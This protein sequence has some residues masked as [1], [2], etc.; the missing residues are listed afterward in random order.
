[1][2]VAE[3]NTE[4]NLLAAALEYAALGWPVLPLHSWTGTRCTCGRDDC[5][6]PAKHPRTKSGLHD[7]TTDTNKISDWWRQWPTANVGLRTGVAF[8]VLDVDGAEGETNLV[9][10]LVTADA[11]LPGGPASFTGGDGRHLLFQPTGAG[12]RAGILPKVDWR[13]TNGYIVA[14]PSLH[15][16]GNRYRWDDPPS[17][18]L[19]FTPDILKVLVSP[20]DADRGNTGEARAL[21]GGTGDGTAY[22]LRALDAEIDELRRA[23]TGTRNHT[24]NQVA[25]N[26]YQ[27]VSGGELA[28]HAVE[29][30]LQATA[31]AIGLGEHETT[32]TIG[33][34]R[35]GG[36]ASPRNAPVLHVL[37][38][39]TGVDGQPVTTARKATVDAQLPDEFW[40]ARPEL[41][42]I[43]Q[44]AR[45]RLVSPDAV[46]GA[47]LARVA[48]ITPHMVEIPATIGS[49]V[50][51]SYFVALAGP[52][53]AGKSS[54]ADIAGELL[55]APD[56]V[57][58]RLPIGSGEGMVEILFDLVVEEDEKGKPVKVKRQT[59]HAAI[60]HIDE[61][62]VLADL[63]NRQGTTLL[64]TLRTAW[65]HGTLGNTNASAERK[66]IVHGRSY[67]YGITLGIQ[68]E[69]AGPLLADAA[70]GTP[71]RFVWVTALDLQ[72]PDESPPWPGEIDWEPPPGDI[73]R[74]RTVIRDRQ[75][76]HPLGIHPDIVRQV[77]DERRAIVR[78]QLEV[79]AG[80]EHQMLVRLKTAALL[81]LLDHR[82][83]VSTDD[84]DLAGVITGV[85]RRIRHTI[86]GTLTVLSQLREQARADRQAHLEIH[87]EDK[88]GQ[89]AL[90][91]AAK[92]IANVVRRHHETSM[93]AMP[94][95]CAKRCLLSAMAGK[96]KELVGA[97]VAIGEAERL[98]WITADGDRWTPGQARPA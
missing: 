51:L 59:R 45:S 17:T 76:R 70:A 90:T 62:A 80:D 64:P 21:P 50:G 26:L 58:D 42:H 44:A 83:D 46:L 49:P 43:R 53:S 91:S 92:S 35:R 25:Y 30:R 23:A 37:T 9:D 4:T 39:T 11:T 95:G 12:N 82:I 20:P 94:V 27:L 10:H 1:M 40:S 48:A 16:T 74:A 52:S 93:H 77:V 61:G 31:L 56:H 55:P 89:R 73:L 3:P 67:V 81:A 24:L 98:E 18:P 60:F 28:E 8:D 71:Q 68:P 15:A 69:K 19:E 96:H 79:A 57:L 2:T 7:A 66:R 6:S 41:E 47:V 33:S 5:S 75:Q 38:R 72:A 13:G 36:M 54:A 29:T 22:G 86:E 88:K 85:S 78:G 84:W 32:Q 65:S 34:A 63:G 14:P 97:D 87:V